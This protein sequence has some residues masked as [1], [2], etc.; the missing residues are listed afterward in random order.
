MKTENICTRL[1][2]EV[3]DKVNIECAARNINRSEWLNEQ[4]SKG[5]CLDKVKI[6]LSKTPRRRISM[7]DSVDIDLNKELLKKIRKII[8]GNDSQIS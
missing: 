4:I 8:S 1:S 3:N 5:R 6:L 2:I 7:D